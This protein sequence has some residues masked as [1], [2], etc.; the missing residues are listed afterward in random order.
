MLLVVTAL[1]TVGGGET[2][3]GSLSLLQ[4]HHYIM[5]THANGDNVQSNMFKHATDNM[6]SGNS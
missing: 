5:L 1:I 6:E 3:E 2:K 4:C